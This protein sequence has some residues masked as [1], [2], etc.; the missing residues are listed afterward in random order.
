MNRA[1][2]AVKT[3]F[4]MLKELQ[5]LRLQKKRSRHLSLSLDQTL[6]L[7]LQRLYLQTEFRD[8]L[9]HALDGDAGLSEFALVL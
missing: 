4:A 8:L 9:L 3:G 6:L 2:Q 7:L 5:L 1:S